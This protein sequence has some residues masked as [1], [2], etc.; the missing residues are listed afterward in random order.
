MSSTKQTEY[1]NYNLPDFLTLSLLDFPCILHRAPPP[2][3][4]AKGGRGAEEGG[5]RGG[6]QRGGG[7]AGMTG[8]V[9]R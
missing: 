3:T 2:S 5:A 1:Y 7:E 4:E 8:L 9:P 6:R